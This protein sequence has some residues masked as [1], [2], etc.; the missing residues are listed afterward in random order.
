MNFNDWRNRY[1]NRN[2]ISSRL[3][4]LTKGN[5]SEEAFKIMLKILEEKTIVGSTTETGF[6]V[7]SKAAVCLQEAPLNAIA[8]NLLYEKALREKS[9][10]IVRYSAFGLRFN[11]AWIYKKGGRPVIYEEKNLMKSIL[12]SDEY[13]RIVN[14][15]LSDNK[16]MV[17][18]THER[19]WRVPGNIQFEY[20]NVEIIVESNTYYQKFIDYCVLKGKIDML[21][22]INGIVV[23]D[24]IFY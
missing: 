22:Q 8:E 2:D 1:K 7:G 11:K 15:D 13:W 20:K 18:W 5:T 19:E 12:P 4:H 9:G 21:R 17:D 3:T 14:Y 16:Y 6:I 10:D 23:L 24:T